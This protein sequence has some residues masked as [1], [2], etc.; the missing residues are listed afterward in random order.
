MITMSVYVAVEPRE[1][2]RAA[3][4]WQIEVEGK[5]YCR[6]HTPSVGSMQLNLTSTISFRQYEIHGARLSTRTRLFLGRDDTY[7]SLLWAE[8]LLWESYAQLVVPLYNIEVDGGQLDVNHTGVSMSFTRYSKSTSTTTDIK[9]RKFFETISQVRGNLRYNGVQYWE[10]FLT[11]VWARRFVP[12]DNVTSNLTPNIWL[13][14]DDMSKAF[15]STMWT[16]LGQV[17]AKPNIFSDPELLRY[18]TKDDFVPHLDAALPDGGY[19]PSPENDTLL[20][21]RPSVLATNYLYQVPRRKPWGSL[22]ISILVADLVLLRARWTFVT[23]VSTYFAKRRDPLANA[24]ETCARSLQG[25]VA[26]PGG[27]QSS[28]AGGSALELQQ[29]NGGSS[30]SELSRSSSLNESPGSRSRR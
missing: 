5:V 29:L 23:F 8:S 30:L 16:D 9:S 15:V 24:C 14:A 21:V 10:Q 6:V 22:V 13:Q 28:P 12:E 26:V 19:I 4:R 2:T 18:F 27:E 3:G 20:D 1:P 17:T 25:E 7:F 11:D